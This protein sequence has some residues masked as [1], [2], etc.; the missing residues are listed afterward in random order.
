MYKIGIV[1]DDRSWQE[2]LASYIKKY[3]GEKG[4]HFAVSVFDDGLDLLMDYKPEYD[5]LLLDIELTHSNGMDVAGKIREQDKSVII[6]F[7]TNM[8]QYAIKGYSVSAMDFIVKPLNYFDLSYRLDKAIS[9]L[10]KVK[11][12]EIVLSFDRKYKKVSVED[13]YYL[14]VKQHH[15]L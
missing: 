9:S 5:I 7:I 4:V 11:R 15:L 12:D 8:A 10:K 14:E 6:I 1:E 13:I 2:L 3:E